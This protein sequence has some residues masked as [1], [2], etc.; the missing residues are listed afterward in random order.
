MTDQF[1]GY[2]DTEAPGE[3]RLLQP[4]DKNGYGG[5]CCQVRYKD[6]VHAQ[7]ALSWWGNAFLLAIVGLLIWNG[8]ALSAMGYGMISTQ[9]QLERTT[10][11]T[12]SM[13][14][15]TEGAING[16]TQFFQE[17]LAKFPDNQVDV[18]AGQLSE[19]V[20]STAQ[21]LAKVEEVTRSA[22][23]DVNGMVH[24]AVVAL[25]REMVPDENKPK[26]SAM[27]DDIAAVT[28]KLRESID[29]LS[30]EEI[31]HGF[32]SVSQLSRDAD[33]VV[34]AIKAALQKHS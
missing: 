10:E 19:S 34:S 2:L 31:A 9:P 17:R 6:P 5:G 32:R 21:I 16:A 28:K 20:K 33:D 1:S 14:V 12:H 18:W 25:V 7:W 4:V 27:V 30:H 3:M 24:A 29:M 22:G 11:Y 13:K 15:S 26:V 8:V 23:T